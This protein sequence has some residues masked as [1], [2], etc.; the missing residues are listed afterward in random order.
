MQLDEERTIKHYH[1]K[2]WPDHGVPT[3]ATDLLGL[4]YRVRREVGG[5]SSP[6]LVHCRCSWFDMQFL[7]HS[8]ILRAYWCISAGVG[9]SGTYV[10]IDTVLDCMN[11]QQAET[12]DIRGIVTQLRMRRMEMVQSV[13]SPHCLNWYVL[14]PLD[15]MSFLAFIHSCS[16]SLFM[17]LCWRPST[18]RKL[19][20]QQRFS[21]RS[22]PGFRLKVWVTA[23]LTKNL[24]LAVSV[25]WILF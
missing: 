2:S 24:R 9:R 16:T 4:I 20:S 12:I 18:C 23:R 19:K 15:S 1:F 25:R 8:F 5:S 3:Y 13:V 7:L 14:C 11:S 22:L 21:V 10:T 6:L 17:M